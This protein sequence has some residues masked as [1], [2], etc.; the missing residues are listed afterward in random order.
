MVYV[1]VIF[2]PIQT[3]VWMHLREP[4]LKMVLNPSL[5][6]PPSLSSPPH[7]HCRIHAPAEADTLSC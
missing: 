7:I 6:R 1:V 4:A 5:S 3:V 2:Q